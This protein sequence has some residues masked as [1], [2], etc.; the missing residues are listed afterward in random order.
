M[1]NIDINK[2]TVMKDLTLD[3]SKA[4]GFVSENDYKALQGKAL[5]SNAKQEP[6]KLLRRF[7]ELREI[8]D[9]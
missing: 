3:I 1:D 6:G 7:H 2:I 8:L 5:E 4:F 9:S